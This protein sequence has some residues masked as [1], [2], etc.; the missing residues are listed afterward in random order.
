L[1]IVKKAFF[2][3]GLMKNKTNGK[4][5]FWYQPFFILFFHLSLPGVY[6]LDFGKTMMLAKATDESGL[7]QRPQIT[8]AGSSLASQ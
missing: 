7:V 3:S 1:G 2:P 6:R 5:W 8:R 4:T